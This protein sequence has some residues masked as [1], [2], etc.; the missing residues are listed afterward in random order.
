MDFIKILSASQSKAWDK[1]TI[2]HTQIKSIDLMERAAQA[3]AEWILIR[4]NAFAPPYHIICGT[5]NNGGDGL[6]IARLLAEQNLEV[7]IY[8]AGNVAQASEEF[9]LNLDRIYA[10]NLPYTIVDENNVDAL[11]FKGTIVDAILGSGI[12][13]PVQGVLKQLINNMNESNSPII[14]ID[15]PS[16][17]GTVISAV[18]DTCVKATCTLSMQTPK[19]PFFFKDYYIYTGRVEVLD[20]GLI[21]A[22]NLQC[23]SKYHYI[24]HEKVKKILKK[25]HIFDHKGTYGHAL[26]IAGSYGKMGAAVLAAKS[27]IKSGAGLLTVACPKSGYEI[28]QT[29]VPEAMVYTIEE[30][31]KYVSFFPKIS[32]FKSMGIGPG[33]ERRPVTRLMLRHLLLQDNLPKL[34]LDADAINMLGEIF[35]ESPDFKIPTDTILTPHPKE[36]DRIAGVSNSAVERHHRQIDFAM[37]HHVYVVLK[38]A[39]TCIACPDGTVYFNSTGNPGMATGGS[40]DVLTGMITALLAQS[41]E[42]KAA[43]ILAVYVHGL[44]G[45]MA[46][47]EV[48]MISA[49]AT[50][51]VQHLSKSFVSLE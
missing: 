6:A 30:H 47:A 15:I 1:Y 44:A 29:T 35:Q 34:V 36:F 17:L 33:L 37:K 42:P 18:P 49:T 21:E 14:S 40:G 12:N 43:S 20:I 27:C 5:G 48:G 3:C 2:D 51:I 38:G 31:E 32:L 25:R 13:R 26:L 41:Y 19:L 23:D 10:K 9:L 16:G 39:Y 28:L 11:S 50:D 45:D 7:L 22:Y 24:T 4:H 46:T 8:L